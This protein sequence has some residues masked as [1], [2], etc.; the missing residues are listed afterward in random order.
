MTK[1]WERRQ[2]LEPRQGL[3]ADLADDYRIY[4]R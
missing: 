2:V 4:E 3:T 1:A